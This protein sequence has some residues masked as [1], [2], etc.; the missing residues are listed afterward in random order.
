MLWCEKRK[1]F[2]AM[3][4]TALAA[5]HAA[6]RKIVLHVDQLLESLETGRDTSLNLQSEISQHLNTLAREVQAL[7]A[8]IAMVGT[9]ERSM[10]RK[11]ITQ[12]QEQS[13]S[14][15]HSRLLSPHACIALFHASL[16]VTSNAH[17]PVFVCSVRL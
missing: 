11:R 9:S 2:Y 1:L 6:A 14:Q 7:E 4:A 15:V 5:H 8:E 16:R 13:N 12:L 10:W 3:A 17:A